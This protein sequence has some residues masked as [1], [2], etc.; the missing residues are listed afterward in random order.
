MHNNL[1]KCFVLLAVQ[2]FLI[3]NKATKVNAAMFNTTSLKYIGNVRLKF[4]AFLT[5]ALDNIMVLSLGRVSQHHSR[6]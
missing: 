2:T 1:Q 6:Q 3:R 5:L 4:N